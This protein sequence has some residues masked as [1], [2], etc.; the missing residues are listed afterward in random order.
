MTIKL[1]FQKVAKLLRLYLQGLPQQSIAEKLSINQATVSLY[2]SEFRATVDEEGLEAAAEEYGIMDI[3]KELHSLGAELKK[4]N[5]VV[6]DAKR[7]LKA[8]IAFE[9]CGVPEDGYKDVVATCIKVE[10]EGFLSAAMELSEIE[11]NSGMPSQQI[12]AQASDSLAQLQKAKKELSAT[13]EK[14]AHVKQTLGVLV[15]QQTDAEKNLNKYL[16]KAGVDYK[17]LEKVE[18]L[19][20]ALNKA[21][22][23]DGEISVYIQRQ[24]LLDNASISFSMLAQ[25]INAA[26]VS[27]GADAGKSLLKKLTDFGGLD[28]AIV[29]LKH[30]KQSLL[31]QTQDLDEKAKLKGAIQT[32]V[33]HLQE[34]KK[35][36][37]GAIAT[38][39]DQRDD[40]DNKTKNVLSEYALG[41][42]CLAKLNTAISGKQMLDHSLDKVIA[43][44]QQKVADLTQLESKRA[45]AV[46][47]LA[48]LETQANR[49]SRQLVILDALEGYMQ[50]T[51]LEKQ[52]QFV[53]VLPQLL[54]G[55][56]QRNY[57]PD[58][59]RAYMFGQLTGGTLKVLRCGPCTARFSVNKPPGITGYRCPV[60]EARYGVT[61]DK[62]EIAIL[63]EVFALTEPKIKGPVMPAFVKASPVKPSPPDTANQSPGNPPKD[64]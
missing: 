22:V 56:K 19:A 16:Q 27:F 23:T 52:A 7:G 46:D 57:S 51:S 18:N 8:A 39:H 3:V 48:K 11:E 32:E 24:N 50:S 21:K 14:T 43:S 20:V 38:L 31:N 64:Q 28:G 42:D 25:I 29:D 12:V 26:K 49:R 55:A 44:K 15:Q 34:Q 35:E 54:E 2:V 37:E 58:F 33:N 40:L 61:V 4:A 6:A 30:E 45:I 10:N 9:E 53:A 41:S 60:C 17:R 1:S 59:L 36:L 63:G 5:L 13:Q 47:E 62:D